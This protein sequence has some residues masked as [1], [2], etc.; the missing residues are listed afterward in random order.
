LAGSPGLADAFVNS[1]MA[2]AGR[3]VL[4]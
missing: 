1:V 2:V 4:R 3:M